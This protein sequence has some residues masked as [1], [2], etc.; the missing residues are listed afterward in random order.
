MSPCGW[1]TNRKSSRAKREGT[2]MLK[3]LAQNNLKGKENLS[4]RMAASKMKTQN[5]NPL[6]MKLL[7]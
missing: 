7:F 3:S 4:L 1:R 2:Q 6:K 5:M